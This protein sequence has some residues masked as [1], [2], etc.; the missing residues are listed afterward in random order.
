MVIQIYR[1]VK[2]IGIH[3]VAENIFAGG[4]DLAICVDEAAELGVVVTGLQVVQTGFSVVYV[5]TTPNE[6]NNL[7]LVVFV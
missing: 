1:I 4:G 5:A 2:T 6:A 7:L 3:I